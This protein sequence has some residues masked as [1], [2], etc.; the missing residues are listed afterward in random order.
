MQTLAFLLSNDKSCLIFLKRYMDNFQLESV[1]FIRDGNYPSVI[2]KSTRD[3]RF[4][5]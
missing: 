5:R 2:L 4:K 3:L 1:F